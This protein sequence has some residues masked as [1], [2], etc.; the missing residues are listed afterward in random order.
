MNDNMIFETL[1]ELSDNQ[2][3]HSKDNQTS[4]RKDPSY[5]YLDEKDNQIKEIPLSK[6][7][8][9]WS[10]YINRATYK[11]PARLLHDSISPLI[12]KN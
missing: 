11:N 5:I 2:S 6:L 1:K 9:A 8:S 12:L 4:K 10:V 3:K 7:N